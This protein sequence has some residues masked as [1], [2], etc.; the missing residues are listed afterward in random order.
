MFCLKLCQWGRTDEDFSSLIQKKI[1]NH[2]NNSGFCQHSIWLLAA[3][4]LFYSLDGWH[5]ILD[6]ALD[7]TLVRELL[8]T[9]I[10]ERNTFHLSIELLNTYYI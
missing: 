10:Q 3:K 9:S 8:R 1:S 4:R 2:K 7:D 6:N 5:I